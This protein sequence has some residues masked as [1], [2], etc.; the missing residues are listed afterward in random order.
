MKW[1]TDPGRSS[2]RLERNIL[3]IRLGLTPYSNAADSYIDIFHLFM[4]TEIKVMI[5]F[6]FI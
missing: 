5:I 1:T 2:K 3:N 6:V 4:N